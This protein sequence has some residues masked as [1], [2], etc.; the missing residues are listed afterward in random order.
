MKARF[1]QGIRFILL[2]FKETSCFILKSVI[3]IDM[4][5]DAAK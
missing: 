3:Q 2:M 5:Q 4:K 1:T